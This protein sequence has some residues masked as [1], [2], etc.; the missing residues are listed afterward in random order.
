MKHANLPHHL[1]VWVDN[2]FLGPDVP[3]GKTYALWHGVHSRE[4]QVLMAHVLLETGAHWSGLPLHA[5]S[6]Y[7]GPENWIDKGHDKLMPWGAMG[8]N[9]EAFHARYLEGLPVDCFRIEETGRHTGII[10]DWSDGFDRYPQEHKP[11]NLVSLDSGQFALHPNNYC[12]FR[13]DHIIKR[14]LFEQCRAYK[15]GEKLYWGD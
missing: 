1:Y 5:M 4:N 14:E 7:G 13:D 3:P 12:R 8:P 11:L 2:E 10:I 15:R 6:A 9:I